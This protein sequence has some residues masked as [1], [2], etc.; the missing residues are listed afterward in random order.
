MDKKQVITETKGYKFLAIDSKEQR[1]IV[2][3][4]DA[5]EG[6]D[7]FSLSIKNG[8]GYSLSPIFIASTFISNTE[9][10]YDFTNDIEDAFRYLLDL[11]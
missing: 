2:I 10:N 7:G 9:I 4:N 8:I 5:K 11:E 6:Y 3:M 1:I